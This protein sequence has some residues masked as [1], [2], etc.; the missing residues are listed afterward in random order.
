M[1]REPANGNN[2]GAP[3]QRELIPWVVDA[4]TCG[5][6][7]VSSNAGEIAFA[8]LLYSACSSSML[9]IN[10][11]AVTSFPM[12]SFVTAF[13]LYF[14]SLVVLIMNQSECVELEDFQWSKVKPYLIYVCSFVLGLFTNM[15]ALSH[16][17]VETAIIFRACAPLAVAFLDWIFLGRQFPRPRSLV[18][19]VVLLVGAYGYIHFDKQFESQGWVAYTWVLLYFATLCFSM[20]FGKYIMNQ[21]P[22]KNM[23]SSVLYTNVL[24]LPMTILLGIYMGEVQSLKSFVFND[25]AVLNIL[26]SSIVGVGISWSGFK[27][28][29]LL[30]ATSYTVVGVM[31]KM[32]TVAI[33]ALIWDQHASTGGIISLFVCI[34]GG[35]MYKQAPTRAEVKA[36]TPLSPKNSSHEMANLLSESSSAVNREH[37]HGRA[38]IVDVVNGDSDA[39][40]ALGGSG[41]TRTV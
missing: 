9:L 23:W 14:C 21:V 16:G 22:L 5:R 31:N 35:L 25:V 13:Q 3:S 11:M 7:Q 34:F 2:G 30:S 18:A 32:V 10:K 38:A 24:G 27:S 28:R 15:M 4:L 36:L 37:K 17:N 1:L 29:H 41:P 6:V 40:S 39:N 12:A 26:L 33:N 8:V 19:L 20:T